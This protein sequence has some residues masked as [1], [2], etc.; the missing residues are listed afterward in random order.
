MKKLIRPLAASFYLYGIITAVL[1][2]FF[3]VYSIAVYVFSHSHGGLLVV[4]WLQN[5]D[6]LLWVLIPLATSIAMEA[7]GI[8]F[9]RV[10]MRTKI[11]HWYVNLK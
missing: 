9:E 10:V 2:I 3:F 7:M 8:G 6:H 5:L 11:C 4:G 1:L